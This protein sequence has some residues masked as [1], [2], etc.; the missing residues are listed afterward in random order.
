MDSEK[1]PGMGAMTKDREDYYP[2][3]HLNLKM[4]FVELN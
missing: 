1:D 3:S 2:Y 4:L